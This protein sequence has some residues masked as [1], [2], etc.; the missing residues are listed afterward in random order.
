MDRSNQNGTNQS[1]SQEALKALNFLSQ[2][3]PKTVEAILAE[4]VD[5]ASFHKHKTLFRQDMPVDYLYL[6]LEGKV[7]EVCIKETE[8]GR[9]RQTLT[10]ERGPGSLLGIY[11]LIYREPHSTRA[12]A[13]ESGRYVRIDAAAINRLIYRFPDLRYEVAPLEKI[14]HLRT[15]PLL[16][17][18]TLMEVS[19]LADGAISKTFSAGE[20]I[21][22]SGPTDDPVIYLIHEGQVKL[23]LNG[24]KSHRWLGNGGAFGFSDSRSNFHSSD[25]RYLLD[26]KA[27]A[28][29]D[30]NVYAI[31]RRHLRQITSIN[32]EKLGRAARQKFRIVLRK[33]SVF[34]NFSNGKLNRLAGFFSHYHISGHHLIT[35]QGEMSDSMWVL[36]PGYQASLR[37]LN[38][39]SQT[40]PTA[41]VQGL[42]FF[43][44][45]SL[46]APQPLESSI[47]SEPNSLWMR[48]HRRDFQAFL[49]QTDKNLIDKISLSH[50][51]ENLIQEEGM[52]QEY[53]WLEDGERLIAFQRRHWIVLIRKLLPVALVTIVVMLPTL[54]AWY[55]SSSWTII[56]FL[57]ALVPIVP[58][59]IWCAIDFENDYLI[60]TNKR[61]IRQERVVF[62][63]EWQQT[64][65]IEQIQNIDI[66][67]T[68]IGN[69]L[70][71]GDLLIQT[72]S[73][74]GT[75]SF[76]FVPKLEELKQKILQQRD[77]YTLYNSATSKKVI[78]EL[79]EE[80]LG[81]KLELPSRVWSE[82]DQPEHLYERNQSWWQRIRYHLQEGRYLQ[83]QE[84]SADH[85]V[86][87][88]HWF[89]VLAKITTPVL[90]ALGCFLF[91]ILTF[92][93]PNFYGL[94]LGFALFVP[95]FLAGVIAS[96]IA[97][98]FYVD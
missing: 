88:K 85:L 18:M 6:I 16:C 17:N 5:E 66:V 15:M 82:N 59:A 26:H 34:R 47:E 80:R 2:S 98:W 68:F 96:C 79:L 58:W 48:L 63:S 31:S 87:R 22:S 40:L 54:I 76:D 12:R 39:S 38:A 28:T 64:A 60:V 73:T 1:P 36:M 37:A 97:G 78:H 89:V 24:G 53:A 71:Y 86:W 56:L 8:D 45:A 65:I 33:I 75:I 20:T 21:Y 83:K 35:R 49:A 91:S 19:F 25:G 43:S 57:L 70:G 92:L 55:F 72:S 13:I 81:L 44:E 74:Y 27:E 62:I 46:I 67:F 41:P 7:R 93:I 77:Q 30:V 84:L 3:D 14:G 11:D 95:I 29:C 90:I 42:N 50:S 69:I 61:V 4:T 9:S 94:E 10:C 51:V 52:R 23:T 32:P